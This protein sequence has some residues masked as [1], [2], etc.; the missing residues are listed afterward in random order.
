LNHDVTDEPVGKG[1]TGE[2]RERKTRAGFPYGGPGGGAEQER[3]GW[4]YKRGELLGGGVWRDVAGVT[5]GR[6]EG[7]GSETRLLSTEYGLSR[8]VLGAMTIQL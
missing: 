2:H 4:K 8:K 6:K 1:G 7:P 5:G 3:R